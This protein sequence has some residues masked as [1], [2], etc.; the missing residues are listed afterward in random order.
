MYRLDE[1]EFN[2][3]CGTETMEQLIKNRVPVSGDVLADYYDQLCQIAE[4]HSS[5]LYYIRRV[6]THQTNFY[7]SSPIDRR[8]FLDSYY[9]DQNIQLPI[10][11]AV[12]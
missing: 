10:K 2:L 11:V 5:N 3:L 6:N 4:N 12:K 1:T 9:K 8:R 7:F